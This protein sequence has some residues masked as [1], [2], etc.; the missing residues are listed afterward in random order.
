MSGEIPQIS[1]SGT[2]GLNLTSTGAARYF[3]YE[4][5]AAYGTNI[6]R[7]LLAPEVAMKLP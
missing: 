5:A 7:Y 4:S 1:N 2:S 6:P 3:D